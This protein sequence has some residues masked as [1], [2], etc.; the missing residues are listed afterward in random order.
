ME[1][2][3]ALAEHVLE[4]RLEL[5]SGV[6]ERMV[7]VERTVGL[8]EGGVAESLGEPRGEVSG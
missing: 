6:G 8:G 7:E 1:E 4:A 2:E 5:D 3:D